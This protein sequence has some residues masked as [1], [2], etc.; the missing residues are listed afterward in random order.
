MGLRL[1]SVTKAGWL[2]MSKA[3]YIMGPNTVGSLQLPTSDSDTELVA[4]KRIDT[5]ECLRNGNQVRYFHHSLVD[6][7]AADDSD[8]GVKLRKNVKKVEI[9]KKSGPKSDPIKWFGFLVP[10]SLRQSQSNFQS[11]TELVLECANIQSEI[12]GVENRIKYIRR[13]KV[14]QEKKALEGLAR[15]M[16]VKQEKKALEGLAD[17]VKSDLTLE[18]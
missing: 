15:R 8:D 11:A 10:A 7:A 9:E 2:H 6:P 13:M 14:K 4:E 17:R 16:K 12:L 5:K 18:E 3:R 1:E